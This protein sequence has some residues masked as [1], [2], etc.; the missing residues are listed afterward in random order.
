MDV[1]NGRIVCTYTPTEVR[2]DFFALRALH[3]SAIIDASTPWSSKTGAPTPKPMFLYRATRIGQKL[4]L[5]FHWRHRASSG[6]VNSA[7]ANRRLRHFLQHPESMRKTTRRLRA[8]GSPDARKDLDLLWLAVRTNSSWMTMTNFRVT[9]SMHL[10][11]WCAARDVLDFSAGWGDR[12]TGFMAASCVQNITLIDP[13]RG[14]IEACRAQHRFV[15]SNTRLTTYMDGA[16]RVL[17]TL[18]T[19]AY[20]L[21]LS[22]PPYFDLERY[23]EDEGDT[24]GQV[25]ATVSSAQQYFDDFLFPVLQHSA[26]V[27]RKGGMLALNIDD[28]PRRELFLCAPT[29]AFLKRIPKLAFLGTAGLKKQRGFGTNSNADYVHCEPIYVF[30]KR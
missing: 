8:N 18:S 16:E 10:A 15:Q 25:W 23:G 2:E 19:G 22:S 29:L 4:S 7:S 21:V 24:A 26:R 3:E 20:D 17:P 11:Q 12:L 28:N 1:R 5:Y 14:S 30:E 27:L 6:T 9:V 13:R